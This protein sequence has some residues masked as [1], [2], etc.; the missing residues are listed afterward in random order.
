MLIVSSGIS[1]AKKNFI[2]K[3]FKITPEEVTQISEADPTPKKSY[4][5][6]LAKMFAQETGTPEQQMARV[7]S[8]TKPLTR[9]IRLLNSPGFPADKRDIGQYTAK[10]LIDLVGDERKYRRNLSDTEIERLI[11]KEGLPGAKIIWDSGGFKMWEVT[12]SKYARFL[13]SN[14]SWCTAQP[15]HSKSYCTSGTLYPI[16]YLGKPFAQGH[17]NNET[18]NMEFLDKDDDQIDVL[19]DTTLKMI[20]TIQNPIMENFKRKVYSVNSIR[21]RLQEDYSQT[22]KVDPKFRSMAL[23]SGNLGVIAEVCRYEWWDEG[24]DIL[25]D[26]PELLSYTMDH[27]QPG[28]LD[29]HPEITD[30]MLSGITAETLAGH[31]IPMFFRLG[32]VDRLID[33]FLKGGMETNTNIVSNYIPYDS[34]ELMK[35]NM[36]ERIN[37]MPEDGYAAYFNT[38]GRLGNS[39]IMHEFWKK[40]IQRPVPQWRQLKIFPDYAK[41]V[42]RFSSFPDTLRIGDKVESG[43]DYE[44]E[45]EEGRT[46]EVTAIDNTNYTV[47]W[48]DGSSDSAAF[49]PKGDE[50]EIIPIAEKLKGEE[51]ARDDNGLLPVGTRVKAIH[52]ENWHYQDQDQGFDGTITEVLRYGEGEDTE[53]DYTVKWDNG[54]S[55]WYKDENVGPVA[56]GKANMTELQKLKVGD[57]IKKGPTFMWENDGE[58]SEEGE[59]VEM[60]LDA[61]RNPDS[62]WVTVR[63]DEDE[64]DE[65]DF[66]LRDAEEN[67]I[68]AGFVYRFGLA[69]KQ[70]A[71]TTEG[72]FYVDVIPVG[73]DA[74]EVRSLLRKENLWDTMFYR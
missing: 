47:Q 20:E 58:H 62:A 44:G 45:G 65:Y 48:D 1:E 10:D 35:A 38:I 9:F 54:Q 41:V 56:T 7:R 66:T 27:V 50:Y 61:N 60:G 49:N 74:N 22:G 11:M 46:G 32:R 29:N 16:Y 12:N 4:T 23:A 51:V 21:S 43:P 57:R 18:S 8:L 24:W 70:T 30:E 33:L 67:G 39:E 34:I 15:G 40:F 31:D 14:T 25:L 2:A 68:E 55:Y 63:W 73:L 5:A 69:E 42:K 72:L 26:H 64:E 19:E 13:S 17:M 59:V 28:V 71:F 53:W 37:A 3:Q 36:I 52:D 6:W